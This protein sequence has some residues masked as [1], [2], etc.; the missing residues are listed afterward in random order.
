MACAEKPRRPQSSSS[1][2]DDHMRRVRETYLTINHLYRSAHIR[3]KKPIF[4]L[5]TDSDVFR[6]CKERT[7]VLCSVQCWCFL[8]DVMISMYNRLR[9]PIRKL[10]F[11]RSLHVVSKRMAVRQDS[12]ARRYRK[13]Q[14]IVS[15]YST[16]PPN[17]EGS[18]EY[19]SFLLL[20]TRM[21]PL[22]VSLITT[23]W[24]S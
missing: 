24:S 18:S 12:S 11:R 14:L 3:T 9:R 23:L 6:K 1:K 13:R 7:M 15:F 5:H 4:G 22:S 2:K 16:L 20:P 19:M 8:W 21:R 10:H 17:T